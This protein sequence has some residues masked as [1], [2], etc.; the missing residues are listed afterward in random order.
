V[1]VGGDE[2]ADD[3]RGHTGEDGQRPERA[4]PADRLGFSYA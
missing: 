3:Q 1:F 2:P 4:A